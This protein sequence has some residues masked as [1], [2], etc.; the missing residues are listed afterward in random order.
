MAPR[1]TPGTLPMPPTMMITR[2]VIDTTMSKVWGNTEPI[3][4]ANKV[5][6]K[7]ARMAPTTKADNLAVTML[8][9]IASATDSSS[10]I[11]IHARPHREFCTA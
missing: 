6:P 5:P 1:T 8:I 4:E 2:T 7:L 10:R 11:A 3:W 9:P